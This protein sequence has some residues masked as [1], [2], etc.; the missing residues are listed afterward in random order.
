[1]LDHLRLERFAKLKRLYGYGDSIDSN[2]P[3]IGVAA[4]SND[5]WRLAQSDVVKAIRKKLKATRLW[6]QHK[7][8]VISNL[9]SRWLT[10]RI[11]IP[12][13]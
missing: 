3:Q 8:V 9:V 13:C 12:E 11:D 5:S 2:S 7:L 10:R 6:D 4:S 1:M